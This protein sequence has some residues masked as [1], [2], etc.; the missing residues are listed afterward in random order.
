MTKL[1]ESDYDLARALMDR[2]ERDGAVH[3]DSLA[4]V[5]MTARVV[6]ASNLLLKRVQIG[7]IAA[8]GPGGAIYG[9]QLES[10]PPWEK[11]YRTINRIN[12]KDGAE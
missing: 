1:S 4:A 7:W 8:G 11:A 3:L 5:C 12:I 2:I 9:R 6:A 10:V